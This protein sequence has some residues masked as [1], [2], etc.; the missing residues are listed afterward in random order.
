M[1]SLKAKLR[2]QQRALDIG[3]KKNVGIELI[4]KDMTLF[5]PEN[6]TRCL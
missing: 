3:N 5:Y 1:I 2:Y 6:F 4:Q